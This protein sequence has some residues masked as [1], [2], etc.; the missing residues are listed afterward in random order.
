MSGP[1]SAGWRHRRYSPGTVLLRPLVDKR[2]EVFNYPKA[3]NL[4]FRSME[5]PS[6]E[7]AAQY[8]PQ[9]KSEP[10]LLGA[11]RARGGE[12][13]YGTEF[14]SF[15]MDEAGVTATIADRESG[16]RETVRADYLIAPTACTARSARRSRL[17]RPVTGRCRSMSSSST[18]GRRGGISSHT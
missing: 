11:T 10:I 9:S 15:D 7:P 6:P 2:D 13:R 4:S 16:E 14:V 3:R 18:S 5:D 17:P 1:V 8:R 12:V